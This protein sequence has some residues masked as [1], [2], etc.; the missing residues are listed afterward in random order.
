MCTIKADQLV[1]G[2][3]VWVSNHMGW[4]RGTDVTISKGMVHVRVSRGIAAFPS[5]QTVTVQ[6]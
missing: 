2:T 1:I 3:L 4:C 5:N 6:S